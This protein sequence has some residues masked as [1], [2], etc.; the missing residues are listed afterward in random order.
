MTMGKRFKNAKQQQNNNI[1]WNRCEH[2]KNDDNV[3]KASL[4]IAFDIY[5]MFDVESLALAL[6]LGSFISLL[7]FPLLSIWFIFF[8]NYNI[9][10]KVWSR[11][12]FILSITFGFAFCIVLRTILCMLYAFRAFR[13]LLFH[14]LY[15]S[16]RTITKHFFPFC[17]YRFWFVEF[18]L[19]FSF[20]SHPF[21][22]KNLSSMPRIKDSKISS[23]V[24]NE[25]PV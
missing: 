20:V 1:H 19:L 23:I 5:F 10:Y 9:M 3:D 16:I 2:N 6:A 4:R 14:A 21:P 8:N 7:L 15:W 25:W 12:S 11:F 17:A 24:S 18:C 22:E 13:Y